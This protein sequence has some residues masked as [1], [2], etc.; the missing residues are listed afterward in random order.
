MQDNIKFNCNECGS[1]WIAATP[2]EYKTEFWHGDVIKEGYCPICGAV[3][4]INL[5]QNF[6]FV[7]SNFHSYHG[8]SIKFFIYRF[9]LQ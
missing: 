9:N 7:N 1:S 5:T 6:S 2:Q 3:V 4:Q 8:R